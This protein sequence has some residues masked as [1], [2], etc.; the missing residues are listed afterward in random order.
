MDISKRYR[1]IT[2]YKCRKCG[3]I[4]KDIDNVLNLAYINNELK[5]IKNCPLEYMECS[6]IAENCVCGRTMMDFTYYLIKEE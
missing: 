3:Q 2:F 6:C 4:V 5:R 1:F